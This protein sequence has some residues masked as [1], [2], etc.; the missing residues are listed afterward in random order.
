MFSRLI[1]YVFIMLEGYRNGIA[2]SHIVS[3]WQNGN[4]SLEVEQ[5]VW[6]N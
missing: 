3:L 6:L 5:E 2:L 1:Y 4:W